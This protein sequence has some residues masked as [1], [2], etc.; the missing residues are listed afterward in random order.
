MRIAG[1]PPCL[2]P[3]AY[4]LR[5]CPALG[6]G[7]WRIHESSV[8]IIDMRGFVGREFPHSRARNLD[9]DH[10]LT[11]SLHRTQHPHK[12][13]TRQQKIRERK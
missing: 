13:P 9:V 6:A 8:W 2:S 4:L 1:I 3:V 12:P 10:G 11:P 7:Q 5:K